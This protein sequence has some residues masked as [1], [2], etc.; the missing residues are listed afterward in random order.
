MLVL[1]G[2]GCMVRVVDRV[3]VRIRVTVSVGFGAR[4]RVRVRVSVC[5]VT[6]LLNLMEIILIR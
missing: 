5:R 3:R 2:S 6:L 1:G 4:V